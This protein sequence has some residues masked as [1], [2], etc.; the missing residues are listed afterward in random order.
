[1]C[2]IVITFSGPAMWYIYSDTNYGGT[3]VLLKEGRVHMNEEIPSLKLLI[4]E[5]L[6]SVR[7]FGMLF[8]THHMYT[9]LTGTYCIC[10]L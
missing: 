2:E 3:H 8:C 7:K 4:N 6:K 9:L 1:M 10:G 5:Q